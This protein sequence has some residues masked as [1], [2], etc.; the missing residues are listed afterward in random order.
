VAEL[1]VAVAFVFSAWLIV[2]AGWRIRRI[3]GDLA[4]LL[5]STL[6]T[7]TIGLYLLTH[8][9]LNAWL[10]LVLIGVGIIQYLFGRYVLGV[11]SEDRPSTG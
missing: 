3:E 8:D 2:L 7:G 4:A 9:R 1:V 5:M 10:V 6:M 11:F